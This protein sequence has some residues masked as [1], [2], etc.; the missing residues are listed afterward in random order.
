MIDKVVLMSAV[1]CNSGLY[2]M[3]LYEDLPKL[4]NSILLPLIKTCVHSMIMI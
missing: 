3:K 1:C 4:R 2:K